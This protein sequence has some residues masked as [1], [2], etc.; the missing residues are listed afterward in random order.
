VIGVVARESDRALVPEFFQLFKTPWEFYRPGGRYDV[1]IASSEFEEDP[2]PPVLMVYGSEPGRLDDAGSFRRESAAE[3]VRV[4]WR[5]KGVPIYGGLLTF[6]A[7]GDP[8]I[9]LEGT[10]RPAVVTRSAD[11]RKILRIGFD[12]FREV[13]FLIRSGQPIE[14]A[15]TPTLELHIAMLRDLILMAGVALVEIPPVPARHT[16]IAC[17][18]HDVDFAGIRRHKLDHTMFGFLYRALFHSLL[19]VLKS[20]LSW[21]KLWKNWLAA[22]SLPLVYLG[23][24]KD[25]MVHFDR[26]VEIEGALPSTFFF[27][28]FKNSPGR[29]PE[30]EAPRKRVAKYDVT[31]ISPD[32]RMLASK[33]K[34]VALHGL[35]AWL[36]VEA[37]REELKRLQGVCAEAS[38]GVRMHWLYFSGRSPAILEKAGFAY[39]T[40]SGY[41]GV[42]GYRS[43]TAQ[44]FRHPGTERMFELPLHVMDTALFLP[45]RMALTQAAAYDIVGKMMTDVSTYGGAL[46]LNW[47]CR[48]LG[49][50]RFWDDFYSRM[51]SEMKERG[52]WFGSAEQVVRWFGKRRSV[53][54][55]SVRSQGSGVEVDL[56]CGPW[57]EGPDLVLRVHAPDDGTR[58]DGN[59]EPKIV[60]RDIPIH[61]DFRQ[62]VSLS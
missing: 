62:R 39:D 46:T 50:E 12:L 59:P 5:E 43:G 55:H 13:E 47:H 57:E 38:A 17:L 4:V 23:V 45:A 58:R 31:E 9:R 53:T 1:I 33:G 49:P 28:P 32:V 24:A 52:A 30:G 56:S 29:C 10:K 40:T 34:E 60:T 18:T 42:V 6:E 11:G 35:D 20:D 22:V 21:G 15:Q 36:D 26:Y 3:G 25:F 7:S 51:L 19:R 54:F 16:F 14:H 37:G 44:V 61:G 2:H 8:L 48:S 27:I 41:N